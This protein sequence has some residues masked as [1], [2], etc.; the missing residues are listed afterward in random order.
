[1]LA[2]VEEMKPLEREIA[3]VQRQMETWPSPRAEGIKDL[4]K[5]QR[6]YAQRLQQ[7]EEQF[8]AP[9]PELRRTLQ[10]ITTAHEEAEAAK[11]R[12]DRSQPPAGGEHRQA[13]HQPRACSS[14]T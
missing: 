5:E 9:P 14:W 12:A 3:R 4:R 1:M 11:K 2:A 13:L 7:F 6:L 10:I 8:G